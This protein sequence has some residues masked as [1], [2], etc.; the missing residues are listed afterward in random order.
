VTDDLLALR[1]DELLNVLASGEPDPGSGS[2]AAIVLAMAAS[3]VAKAARSPCESWPE[4]GGAAAQAEAL[5]ARATPLADADAL[6]YREAHTRLG[7]AE[8]ADHT[9]AASLDRA[10]EVPLEITR[11]GAD[12][13]ALARE[14]ADRCDPG[15]RPDV[16]GA[17]VLAAAAAQTAAQL[18]EANLT[19]FEGDPRVREANAHADAALGSAADG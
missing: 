9:L 7:R 5:R 15:L 3:L 12:V 11:I 13:A 16:L 19:V 2:A 10:A 17:A 8:G 14:V 1:V 18:V 4:A 6:V